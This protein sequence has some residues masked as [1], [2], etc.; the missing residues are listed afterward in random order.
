MTRDY[1][2]WVENQLRER[3]GLE[4]VPVVVDFRRAVVVRASSSA[5]ERGGR[6]SRTCCASAGT[7][8]FVARRDTLDDA[9]YAE[10]ELVV[11]AVP[12]HAFREVLAH[13][14]GDAP[15]L[16]LA[17]GLDPSTGERLSTLVHDRP[18]AVLSGPEHGGGGARRPAGRD[19]DRIATTNSSR[20]GCRTRSTRSRSAST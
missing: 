15:I 12:S 11:L 7:T 10:A 20:S 19:R 13:V 9:P 18:V 16:S 1:G 6:Q 17:K 3:L 5:R 4:G 2:Y 14:G 8:C